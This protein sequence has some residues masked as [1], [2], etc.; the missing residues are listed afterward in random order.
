MKSFVIDIH[1]YLKDV[2]IVVKNGKLF[3]DC[4]MKGSYKEFSFTTNECDAKRIK[5]F[6]VKFGNDKSSNRG[7]WYAHCNGYAMDLM[8]LNKGSY[9]SINTYRPYGR[10]K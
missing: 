8:V 7:R 10:S 3:S 5:Q 6:A 1:P 4:L 9:F 2:E